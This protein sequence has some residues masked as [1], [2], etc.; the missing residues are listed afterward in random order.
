M[1]FSF[2]YIFS[3]LEEDDMLVLCLR[4]VFLPPNGLWVFEDR[5]YAGKLLKNSKLLFA[6]R[7]ERACGQAENFNVS[8]KI[9]AH[10]DTSS[11][12]EKEKKRRKIT[13]WERKKT[14]TGSESSSEF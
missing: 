14:K 4:R 13:I 10:T 3:T 7:G 8:K 5:I 1:I 11:N 2:A 12:G 6:N 9:V